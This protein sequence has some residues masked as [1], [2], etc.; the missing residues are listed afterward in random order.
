MIA[1]F[2]EPTAGAIRLDGRDLLAVNPQ[3]ARPWHR[4]PELRAVSAHDGRARTSPSAWRC[5]RSRSAERERARRRSAGAGRAERLRRTAIRAQH[6]RRPA[7]ARGARPR[8]GDPARMCCCSTSRC[9]ISTPSCARKCR[10]S[11]ARIQ[12]TVGITT[13]LVTHDQ[14]EAHGA[15]RPHRR[16]ERGPR[17]ADRR[18]HDAYENP[19]T[20][21]RLRASSARPTAVRVD[22]VE[23]GTARIGPLGVVGAPGSQRDRGPAT[24]ILCG[25]R[26]SRFGAARPAALAGNGRTRIFQGNHWLYQCRHAARAGA[27]SSGR[28]T[29]RLP[30]SDRVASDLAARRHARCPPRTRRA[31]TR[32]GSRETCRALLAKRPGCWLLCAGAPVRAVIVASR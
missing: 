10:S 18:P 1:G 7:A 24:R 27:R 17:R 12:R 21:I 31:M 8:A 11:C 15:V 4:L 16:D 32:C 23:G 28:T 26:R 9:R 20:R 29:A 3:P 13:I 5:G 6:V 2:V 19:A 22:R 14:A 30:P 25:P